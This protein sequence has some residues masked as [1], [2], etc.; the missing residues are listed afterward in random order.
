MARYS[1]LHQWGPS[2]N[3]AYSTS[4][5]TAV[6]TVG[7]G[8][9]TRFLRLRAVGAPTATGGVRIA[10]GKAPAANANSTYLPLGWETPDFPARPALCPRQ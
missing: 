4:A 6:S 7:F 5:G 9:S 8:N 1:D 3:L 2:V 10:I